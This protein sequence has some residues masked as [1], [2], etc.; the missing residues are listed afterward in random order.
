MRGPNPPSIVTIAI[1][2]TITII[3]W[4]FFGVYRV[5]TGQAEVNVPPQALTPIQPTLN[6]EVLGRLEQR[7]YF[8]KNTSFEFKRIPGQSVLIIEQPEPTPALDILEETVDENEE[9]EE[10]TSEADLEN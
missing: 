1:L 8:E 9:T 4:I 3:F 6:Q 5:L 10:A 2:T 7:K